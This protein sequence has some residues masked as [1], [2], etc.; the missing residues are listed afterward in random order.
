MDEKT[1]SELKQIIKNIE[2]EQILLPNF[3]REFTWKDEKMQIGLVCSVLARMPVGSILLL[4]STEREFGCRKI[5]LKVPA[6]KGEDKTEVQYLLD[7]QQR[8]TVLSNVFSNV[9]FENMQKYSELNSDSLK[10]RFFIKLPKWKVLFENNNKN[11]I[12]GIKKLEFPILNP[13]ID[14]PS[15]LTGDVESYIETKT[16]TANDKNFFNPK[17]GI[18]NALLTGCINPDNY[19]IPLFLLAPTENTL[20]KSTIYLD[21][22]ISKIAE[23]ISFEIQDYYNALPESDRADFIKEIIQNPNEDIE[24]QLADKAQIWFLK[25]KQYLNACTSKLSLHQIVLDREDR[26]RAIDIYEN[27]NK[28]GVTLS[29]FDL[30]VAKVAKEKPENNFYERIRNNILTDKTK[31]EDKYDY[32]LV[33]DDIKPVVITA[34]YVNASKTIQACKDNTSK[35]LAANFTDPF[36]NLLGLIYYSKDK[37]FSD[38]KIDFTKREQVLN[39]DPKFIDNNCEKICTALDRAYFFFQTRCGIRKITEIN[40]Q[41]MITI[42]ALVFMNKD[43]FNNK[44]IHN[45]LEAWYWGCVFSGE[46]NSDQND[47]AMKNI[48]LLFKTFNEQGDKNWLIAMKDK[49]FN[50]Q[51]FSKKEFILMEYAQYESYPKKPFRDFICQYFLSRTYEDLLSGNVLSVFSNEADTLEAHHL[52]PVGNYKEYEQNSSEI[53]GDDKHIC[54]SPINFVYITPRT[55]KDIGKEDLKNYVQRITDSAKS[56]LFIS[57]IITED[58]CDKLI[59]DNNSI[60]KKLEIAK[61]IL[62]ERFDAIKGN[63]EKRIGILL[64]VQ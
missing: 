20:D 38:V 45:V 39:I 33:Y 64:G 21:R 7:G 60:E 51:N 36:L 49:V 37:N 25:M 61:S 31:D 35:D 50:C 10:R 1:T 28:G 18:T 44:D 22:I 12:F 43:L 34:N 52:L 62:S 30:I 42:I 8:V 11:D 17:N 63:V 23:A 54:N 57:G 5:G 15:F 56:S 46:F 59:D 6:Q 24:H 14:F 40:Y 48:K 9:I 29:T 13:D 16:F 4:K 47:N 32:N 19:L 26:N 58:L 41:W 55:N 2:S 27:L 3:Q 53:R